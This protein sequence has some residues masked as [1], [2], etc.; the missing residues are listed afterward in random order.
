MKFL[1]LILFIFLSSKVNSIFSQD[2]PIGHCHESIDYNKLN[3]PL[4]KLICSPKTTISFKG[5]RN[6]KCDFVLPKEKTYISPKVKFNSYIALRHNLDSIGINELEGYYNSGTIL[7]ENDSIENT[8]SYIKIK[9]NSNDNN[10]I[11]VEQYIT[12]FGVVLAL[13]RID[14]NEMVGVANYWVKKYTIIQTESMDNSSNKIHNDEL[15]VTLAPNP[16]KNNINIYINQP[17]KL[18]SKCIL[19]IIDLNQGHQIFK[20]FLYKEFSII[21][22]SSIKP[23]IYIANIYNEKSN[24]T[25]KLIKL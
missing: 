2:R 10:H 14:Y 13:N 1:F 3:G 9:Y 6:K 24:V 5:T 15:V 20:V 17:N 19:E 7:L 18:S 11:I 12:K 23:G 21:D 16:A 22:I 25:T 4:S 8:L